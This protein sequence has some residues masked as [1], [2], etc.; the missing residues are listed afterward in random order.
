MDSLKT[1]LKEDPDNLIALNDLAFE[2]TYTNLDSARILLLHAIEVNNGDSLQLGMSM[3]T[4]AIVYGIQG[5]IASAIS[6]HSKSIEIFERIESPSYLAWA[7]N[8]LGALYY[9]QYDYDQALTYFLK[10][11]NLRKEVQN[12]AELAKSKINIA[13]IFNKTEQYDSALSYLQSSLQP[14]IDEPDPLMQSIVYLNMGSTFVYLSQFDSA[15]YFYKKT[16]IIQKRIEDQE[17]LGIL[18]RKYGEL[19]SQK[20]EPLKALEYY[21]LSLSNVLNRGD[22]GR[23]IETK[24]AQYLL[25]EKM[26]DYQNAYQIQSDYLTFRDS[27]INIKNKEIINEYNT[28]YE[29]EQKV[30]TIAELELEQKNAAL[31]LA[32]SQNQRNIFIS[33]VAILMI[34]IGFLYQRYSTK[35]KTSELLTEKNSEITSALEDREVLLKEIHHRVK[36]NLQVISSLL[37]LQ[38]GSLDD[39]AAKDAVREGQSRV[40]SMALIHQKLYSADDVRGVDIQDYLVN[41]SSELFRAF[42]VDEEKVTWNIDA[43]GLKMDIDTVIP[44]GLII[45]ELI[46]NSIKYAFQGAENGLLDISLKEI[47]GI[48]NVSVIDNGVGMN[49]EA[50]KTSNSFGWKMIKSLSR[51]L[52]AE[53]EVKNEQGTAVYLTLS[54]YKL[55]E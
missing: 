35:K 3:E 15:E 47:N 27:L 37:N 26:G 55:V 33:G 9:Q 16:E 14:F 43:S 20:N 13:L 29:T 52:K 21:D 34:F 18:Y 28:K 40:K 12:P 30:R 10:A 39:D 22:M 2:Y 8:D 51:K 11:M 25:Y 49:E 5:D 41:L 46:T 45:N 53:I 42:G 17:G 31:A 44:L 1:T 19:Y 32:N 54:R 50:L 38:A 23:I 36:N 4:L 7:Y 48:L 24:Q 6:H